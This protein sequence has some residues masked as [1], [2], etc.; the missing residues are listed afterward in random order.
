ML[1]L[2]CILWSVLI[3]CLIWAALFAL[4]ISGLDVSDETLAWTVPISL[5]LG[6]ITVASKGRRSQSEPVCHHQDDNGEKWSFWFIVLAL[7]VWIFLTRDGYPSE[8]REE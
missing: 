4:V 5:I 3:C 1:L 7:F 6:A 2:K 8:R